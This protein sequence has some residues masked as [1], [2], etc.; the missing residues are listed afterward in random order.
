M[1]HLRQFEDGVGVGVEA[2]G[3]GGHQALPADGDDAEARAQRAELPDGLRAA[4]VEWRRSQQGTPRST[5]TSAD[6]GRFAAA[7]LIDRQDKTSDTCT[8]SSV[9]TGSAALPRRL[10]TCR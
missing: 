2:V 9:E 7:K 8:M 4:T 6:G 10:T 1:R 3:N 5:V